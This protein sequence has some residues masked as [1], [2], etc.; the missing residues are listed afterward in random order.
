MKKLTIILGILILATTAFFLFKPQPI[1]TGTRTKMVYLDR[2]NNFTGNNTFSGNV[3]GISPNEYWS[4]GLDGDVTIAATT[5]TLTS[6]KHYKKLTIADGGILQT[7]GYRVY[8]QEIEIQ[9]G[10][11]ISEPGNNGATA[12]YGAGVAAHAVGTLQASKS[13]SNQGAAGAAVVVSL[14][15]DGAKGGNGYTNGSTSNGGAKGTTTSV[16]SSVYKNIDYLKSLLSSDPSSNVNLFGGSA[17]SGGGGSIAV[18]NKWGGPSGS[19]GGNVFLIARKITINGIIDVYG[20]N[21]ANGDYYSGIYSA[22]GGGGG[23]AGVL[24][25]ACKELSGSGTVNIYG[26][27]GGSTTAAGSNSGGDGGNGGN[28]YKLFQTDTSSLTVNRNGGTAGTGAV[29]A[30]NGAIGTIF[31][32]NVDLSY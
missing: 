22:G 12:E 1:G 28:F 32:V 23:S 26:G 20:G 15:V 25:L 27:N 3:L 7:N 29:A 9:V 31:S 8:A 14:G 2:D 16:T 24:V 21:G 19:V 4:Q 17:G 13:G 18:A 11:K 30:T 5:T 6:D 10:G